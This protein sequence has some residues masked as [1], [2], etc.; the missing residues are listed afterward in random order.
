MRKFFLIPLIISSLSFAQ[1]WGGDVKKEF[2]LKTGLVKV[3]YESIDGRD[4]D[5]NLEEFISAY[6]YLASETASGFTAG[7]SIEVASGSNLG[8]ERTVIYNSVELN[9]QVEFPF[10]ERFRFFTGFGGSINRFK[11]RTGTITNKD[12]NLG[13]QFFLGGKYNI[14]PTFGILGEYKGKL[15]FTGDYDRGLIHHF[16][17][18]IYFLVE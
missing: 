16:N 10:G 4:V 7:L 14:T 12:T 3:N 17:V 9:P 6:G 2:G 15:F 8:K 5:K 13:L 11:E 1:F 18:G